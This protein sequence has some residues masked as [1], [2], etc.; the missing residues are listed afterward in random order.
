LANYRLG[1]AA[2]NENQVR[3]DHYQAKLDAEFDIDSPF[4]TGF[5]VGFRWAKFKIDFLPTRF[6]NTSRQDQ[7]AAAFGSLFGPAEFRG[8]EFFKTPGL[9]MDFLTVDNNLLRSDFNGFLTQVGITARPAI[10]LRGIYDIDEETRAA[11]AMGEFRIEGPISIDGNAGVRVVDTIVDVNGNQPVFG[12]DASGN[13]VQTG[14]APISL[15]NSYL[16]VLPS[17]NVRIGLTESLQLRL[18]AAK[19]LT[20]PNFGQLAPGLTLVPGQGNGSGGNPT[21][22]PLRA[23]QIDASLEYYLSR[24]A[25]VYAAGFYR[26]VKDF[27]L[28]TSTSGVQIGDIVYTITR[29]ENLEQG[30][31]KGF[32]VGGQTFFDFLPSPFD[33]FGLQANYTYVKSD[34]PSAIVGFRTP[35]PNLSKHSYNLIGLYEKGPFSARVAYN[36]RSKFLSGVFSGGVLG[37]LPVYR[38]GYGWLDAS[39]NYDITDQFSVSLEGSNLLRTREETYYDVVTR[40]GNYSIDDRQILFGIRFKL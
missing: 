12:R 14:F 35:L 16:S 9:E 37:V 40:P 24:S 32:E 38:K 11:Y 30:E 1:L 23:D 19:T 39:I 28:T 17:A 18:A 4:M 20:R 6:F 36:Y 15:P 7:P 3:G 33:G 5:N 29:P 10:D 31:I 22:K 27:V 21:L 26:K 8:E 25:Y 34:T 2:Y 13:L